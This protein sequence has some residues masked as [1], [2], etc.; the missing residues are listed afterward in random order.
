MGRHVR[1]MRGGLQGLIVVFAI[2][3]MLGAVALVRARSRRS[4]CCSRSQVGRSRRSAETHRRESGCE[5][6]RAVTDRRRFCGRH[7]NPTCR[8]VEVLLAAGAKPDVAN[9]FGVTPLLQASRTGD[10]AVDESAA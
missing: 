9:R 7:T 4:S 3:A 1:S 5:C 2:A 8:H 10:A 6:S